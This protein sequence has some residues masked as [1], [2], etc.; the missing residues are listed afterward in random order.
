MHVPV[1]QR[2]QYLKSGLGRKV[3]KE[4]DTGIFTVIIVVCKYVLG[5]G[6]FLPKLTVCIFNSAHSTV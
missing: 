6:F 2:G 5:E 4:T 3:L 1:D